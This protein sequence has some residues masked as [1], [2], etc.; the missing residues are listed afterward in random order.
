LRYDLLVVCV[1]GGHGRP[2]KESR[3]SGAIGRPAGRRVDPSRPR[4]PAPRPRPARAPGDQLV[5]SAVSRT[6][7]ALNGCSSPMCEPYPRPSDAR[8]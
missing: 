4:I 1:G 6:S 7:C 2:T 8:S 5:A 3:R